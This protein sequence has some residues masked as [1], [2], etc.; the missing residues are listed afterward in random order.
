[1]KETLDLM[2][3]YISPPTFDPLEIL[4]LNEMA[5]EI[6]PF[7]GTCKQRGWLDNYRIKELLDQDDFIDWAYHWSKIPLDN[8][9]IN[10]TI[11][12]LFSNIADQLLEAEWGW[13]ETNRYIVSNYP[14]EQNLYPHFDA[15]YLWP[16]R[17]EVQLHRKFPGKLSVTFMVPLIEFNNLNGATA[18]VPGTH[19]YLY[20][21][22]KWSEM[23]EFNRQFFMDNYYQAKVPLGSFSCFYGNCMHSIMPNRTSTIRRGIILRAI[24]KDVLD[25]MNTL[26]LG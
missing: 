25:E 6:S 11:L 26:G 3:F 7:V 5:S 13:Q 12:P 2:G 22:A 24:R 23:E 18:F 1:M 19:K 8:P 21:T 15:P 16:H 14:Q 4:K 9:F 17:Q 20:D 10:N